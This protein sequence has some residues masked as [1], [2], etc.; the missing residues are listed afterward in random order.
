MVF[1]NRDK[2]SDDKQVKSAVDICFLVLLQFS[3]FFIFCI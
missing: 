1:G 3:T 2:G